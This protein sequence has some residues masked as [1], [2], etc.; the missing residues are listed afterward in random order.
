MKPFGGFYEN[1]GD[2]VK[3]AKNEHFQKFLSHPKVQTLMSDEE[4]RKAIQEK[5]VFKLLSHSEFNELLRDSEVRSALQGMQEG[6][7]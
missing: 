7:Q 2:F 5:N 4:F 3:L 6:I 1:F